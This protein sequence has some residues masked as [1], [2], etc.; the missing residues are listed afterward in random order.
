MRYVARRMLQSIPVLLGVFTLVFIMLRVVP[1]DPAMFL[2]ES[3][4]ITPDLLENLRHQLGTDRPIHEQYVNTLFNILRG[5]MGVSF[6][7]NRPVTALIWEF[8]PYSIQLTVTAMVL[9][10]VLGMIL[11]VISAIKHT[12]WLD[13]VAMSI[14]VAG[15]AIPSFWLGLMLVF[16]FVLRLGWFPITVTGGVGWQHLILPALTLAFRPLAS[17][18]RLTRAS[19]LEV[20]QQPYIVTARSKGLIERTVLM[21]HAL[22]NALIP[23]I[24]IIGID[25]AATLSNAMIIEIVFARPGLGRLL[26]QA[27][28]HK[29][30]PTTQSLMLFIAF[31]YFLANVAVDLSY[32]YLDPRIQ[33]K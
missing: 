26:I 27:I 17:I 20:L 12:S 32:G 3:G 13:N 24:T 16:V 5:D 10:T 31:I 28:I 29:D 19:F 9:A 22:K 18:A 33:L 2:L 15:L 14:S 30:F 7:F 6:Y 11:G 1:G 4:L 8:A 23:V 25:V 21:R